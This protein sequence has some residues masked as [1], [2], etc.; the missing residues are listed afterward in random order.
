MKMFYYLSTRH[1]VVNPQHVYQ[2]GTDARRGW[3][4]FNMVNQATGGKVPHRHGEDLQP[5][6][7]ECAKDTSVW[8]LSPSTNHRQMFPLPAFCKQGNV[9]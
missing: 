5:L 7:D 9:N 3:V 8:T 4:I 2:V 1:I 6:K